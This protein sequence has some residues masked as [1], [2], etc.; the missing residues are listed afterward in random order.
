MAGHNKWTQIKRKKGVTDEA[1]SKVFTKF[2]RL[3][4]LEAKKSGGNTDSPGL[5]N[6][7]ERARAINMPS[8][9]IERAIK[10][11]GGA[12]AGPMEALVYEAYGPGGVALVI[13]GLT[14]NRNKASSEIKHILSKHGASLGAIGSASWAFTKTNDGWEPNISVPIDQ[15]TAGAL[16]RLVEE[17]EGNDEVQGVYLNA[18]VQN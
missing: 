4:T 5:K 11:A 3:I 6:V 10:R 2:A 9:N 13:D 18:D 7:V 15:T 8:V 12:E 16:E 14:D 1:R 17:L